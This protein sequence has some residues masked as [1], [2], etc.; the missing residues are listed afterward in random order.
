MK[1]LK[2]YNESLDSDI[3]SYVKDILLELEDKGIYTKIN[4]SEIE[5]SNILLY[6]QEGIQSYTLSGKT[7]ELEQ[8]VLSC[9]Y[10]LTD[11]L[12]EEGYKIS[13]IT[14]S[15]LQSK[16]E[17]IEFSDSADN[18]EDLIRIV[19]IFSYSKFKYINLKYRYK[20]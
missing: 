7:F 9:L 10:H 2:R 20:G 8:D 1:Y 15:C 18:I 5:S 12:T 6:S 16:E 17:G 11:Y 4:L 13:Y 19:N 14:F 3:K